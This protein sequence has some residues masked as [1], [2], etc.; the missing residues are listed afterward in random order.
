MTEEEVQK[1]IL[2]NVMV[3]QFSLNAGLKCFGERGTA[4]ITKELKQLHDMET[5]I[6]VDA[7][8]LSKH[9][10][11]EALSSL[12]FLTEKQDGKIKAQ[13][14]AAGSKQR[15]EPGYHKEDNASP[16]MTNE[17]VFITAAIDAYEEHKVAYMDIP[18]AY[19]HTHTIRQRDYHAHEG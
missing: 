13:K 15:C 17:S 14:C 5:Y 11:A 9:Q 7:K 3:Q 10:H 8:S 1:H 18:G 4:A 2:S 12:I 16:T 19:L 6:P